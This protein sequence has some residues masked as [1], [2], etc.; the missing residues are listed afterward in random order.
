MWLIVVVFF[1]KR[2]LFVLD[3]IY[4]ELFTMI[5]QI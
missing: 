3:F 2:K 4:I 1:F 5:I